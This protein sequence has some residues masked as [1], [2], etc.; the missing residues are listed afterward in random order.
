M[1]RKKQKKTQKQQGALEKS[2]ILSIGGRDL[3]DEL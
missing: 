1:Q 2:E 3:A